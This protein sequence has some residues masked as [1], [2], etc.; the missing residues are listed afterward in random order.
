MSNENI[1]LSR[2][3]ILAGIGAAGVASVGAGLGTSAYFN[4]VESFDGNTIAAGELDL[5]VDWEEHYA[6]PQLLGFEDPTNGLDYDI[7]YEEPDGDDGYVGFP[8]PENPHVW[9]HEDDIPTYM[10]NTAIEAFPDPDGDGQQEMD[11]DEF[12]YWPCDH[13][14]DLPMHLDPSAEG[15]L[16][17]DN[18]DTWNEEEE[19]YKP[20]LSLDDVKPGDFGEFTLSFHL[21]DNPGY[22]WLQAANVS[23]SEN[24]LTDPESE[25]DD[26]P[27]EPELAENIQTA[28]WYDTNG[29]NVID[30]S[31]G[32]VDVMIAVDTSGSLDQEDLDQ[33]E[34]FA[35]DLSTSL[36]DTGNARVG[37]LSF[38]GGMVEDFTSLADGPAMFS[39]LEANGN[40][41]MPAALDV[42]REELDVNGRSDAETFII[43]FSD[44]GPNYPNAGYDEFPIG[45]GYT[46]GPYADGD[47]SNA[48]VENAELCE[49]ATIAADIRAD[50]RILTVGI[51]DDGAITGNPDA[52]DCDGNSITT[53]S[54]Y[55]RDYISG[56]DADYYSAESIGDIGPILD[57]ILANVAMEEEVFH[58]GTLADD[59]EAL[60]D[61]NGI[62]LDGDLSTE[63]DELNDPADDPDRECFD[64]GVNYFV[65]FAWW[66][67]RE[68]GNEVQSDSVGFDLGFYTE[69]CRHNDGSGETSA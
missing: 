2:R 3:K 21:C 8:D 12:T 37:G 57:D 20:L 47:S 4:D 5:K 18:G 6:Y 51:D 45:G 10:A 49:T 59:L 7:L 69:Q 1:G 44:G 42:A 23:E 60:A 32:E 41:P 62:P 36:D 52:E 38:G 63:F 28:W 34:G 22:V 19:D 40:T 16:R 25:V 48:I 66:L 15:A 26:S 35:N 31:I 11:N 68:V 24:G 50:H 53:L 27:E 14:A 13:G 56:A 30:S 46:P 33:L 43:V 29:N 67:P 58:R 61:G 9:V 55:L 65:G 64:P 39:D 54:A 17:T